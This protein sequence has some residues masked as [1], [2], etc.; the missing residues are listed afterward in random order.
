MVR[1]D[2]WGYCAAFFWVETQQVAHARALLIGS[3]L[4]GSLLI[5]SLAAVFCSTVSERPL[6]RSSVV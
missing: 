5:G 1:L 6:S 2:D 4:I 3:L